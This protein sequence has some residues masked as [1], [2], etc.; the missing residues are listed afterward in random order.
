MGVLVYPAR[1]FQA[2]KSSSFWVVGEE[3]TGNCTAILLTVLTEG[4]I[5][6][7]DETFSR[8]VGSYSKFIPVGNPQHPVRFR[9]EFYKAPVSS[10][11]PLPAHQQ[12]NP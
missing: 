2:T 6:H 4:D 1:F 12:S 11:N 10:A 3:K 5:N 8:N 7:I 9:D